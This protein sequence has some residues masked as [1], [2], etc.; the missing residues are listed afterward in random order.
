MLLPSRLACPLSLKIANMG[1]P[2]LGY[3]D[4]PDTSSPEHG[5]VGAGVS[6]RPRLGTLWFRP[7]SLQYVGMTPGPARCSEENRSEV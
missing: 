7:A 3:G 2:G 4:R 5:L 6:Y 1:N